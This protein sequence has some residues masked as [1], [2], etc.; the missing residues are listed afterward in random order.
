MTELAIE[1]STDDTGE[2][3]IKHQYASYPFHI[4]RAQYMEND[5][6]GMANVYIQSASG[7]IYENESLATHIAANNNSYSHTTTQASTIVHSMTRGAAE[8]LISLKATGKAYLEYFSDPLILFPGSKLSSKIKIEADETSVVL[9]VD[10]FLV[11]TKYESMDIFGWYHNCLEVY[12]EKQ[13][14]LVKDVYKANKNNFLQDK[15]GH[16]G[17]GTLTLI[18]R[19][20]DISTILVA[21]Q[22]AIKECDDIYGGTTRL[23]NSSGIIVKLLA[24]DGDSLKKAMLKIWI[25]SRKSIT[26]IKPNA[27]RK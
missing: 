17:L 18:K 1:Y 14:L 4:C 9:L 27:R 12:S 2:T 23:P 15:N 7:G 11:N 5:P 22:N 10:A 13:S 25:A 21:L 20:G 26:G 19:S 6:A 16:I 8:Q 3:F 24:R